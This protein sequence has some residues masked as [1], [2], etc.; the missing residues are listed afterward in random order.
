MAENEIPEELEDGFSE[1]ELFEHHRVVCDPGQSPLRIDKFLMSRIQYATRSRIQYGIETDSVKVND[2]STKPS[3]KVKPGDVITI[4]LP[5]PPREDVL[6]PEDIPLDIVYE[7]DQ[8]LIVNKKPGMVVHPAHGN[9]T[10]TLVNAL[11]FH[12][13]NLPTHVNGKIR[14]GLIHR[15]DKDT[16]GLLVIAK[17]DYAMTFMAKQFADH[18]IERT[19]HA[20]CWGVP[21]PKS[22]TIKN[23]LG[24]STKDRKIVTTYE[25]E[26]DGKLAI[27]HFK[28]LAAYHYVA[29]IQCNLET[30]RTHQIRAHMKSIGHSLFNDVSYGGDSVVKGTVTGKYKQF[31]EN[32][33]KL[34]PRQA[35]HAKTLGFIHPTTKEFMQFDSKLPD[36]MQAVLDKWERYVGEEK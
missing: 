36:D 35:L 3:Y 32:C 9:W 31:V 11:A 33:F 22:G 27:T 24:R 6:I 5:H 13:E 34:L 19:Y 4:S 16:S 28:T 23:Y 29:L 1:D 26:E 10:G 15:I 25:N 18:S 7:D 14:P 20:I 30:G 21:D 12:F 17:T 8:I 2:K